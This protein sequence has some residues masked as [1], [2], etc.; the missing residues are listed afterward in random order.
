MAGVIC[1]WLA[2]AALPVRHALGGDLGES[3]CSAVGTPQKA[4]GTS[5]VHTAFS[6]S[7]LSPELISS[8]FQS[9]TSACAKVPWHFSVELCG[10][11]SVNVPGRLHPVVSTCI[12]VFAC[13][14]A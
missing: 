10:R 9:F 13:C 6:P 2:T 8:L 1:S 4:A 11:F 14:S 7:F 5:G 12:L 3:L